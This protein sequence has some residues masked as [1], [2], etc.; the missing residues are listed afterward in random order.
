MSAASSSTPSSSLTP[1]YAGLLAGCS[2]TALLYPLELIKV[3]MQVNESYSA[4]GLSSQ[5]YTEFKTLLRIGGGRKAGIKRFR[6]LYNGL[7]PSLVG[8]GV[9]WGG[10]F[11]VYEKTKSL[12]LASKSSNGSL[13]PHLTTPEYM[14]SA[15]L[16]G[17][18]MVLMT[19]PIW[20]IKTRIQLQI[21]SS[22]SSSSRNYSGIFDALR[23]IIKTEGFLAL[24]KGVL[25]ALALVSHGMVQFTVYE[26]LKIIFPS[27]SSLSKSSDPTLPVHYRLVDSFGYLSFGAMSKIVASM[28]TY[29][30]Q[31][32]KSRLQQ[33]QTGYEIVKLQEGFMEGG[34]IKEVQRNYSTVWGTVRRIY[35]KEG[36]TGFFKGSVANGVRVAP[37]A[38]V[39]FL[40]YE[41]VVDFMR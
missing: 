8:N 36:I 15:A 11:Y 13:P 9:S 29:P 41:G 14:T 35:S 22:N 10:Y 40:V 17:A 25:P 28:L 33:R 38:A 12:L 24:Y 27:Y 20:L 6:G 2:S 26:N 4:K 1:L 39:T 21:P 32:V 7:F 5:F 37:N 16:S 3:R 34:E 19:N 31:V 18:F 30:V 23:Q